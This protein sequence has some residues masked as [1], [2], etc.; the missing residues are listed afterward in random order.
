MFWTRTLLTSLR[1][2]ASWQPSHPGPDNLAAL[3]DTSLRVRN[4]GSTRRS[5]KRRRERLRPRSL[6]CSSKTTNTT[7]IIY[8]L[9]RI[10]LNDL[11]KLYFEIIVDERAEA[12]TVANEA[13]EVVYS[14]SSG[15]LYSDKNSLSGLSSCHRCISLSFSKLLAGDD[16]LSYN[17]TT[18]IL[19]FK[20]NF[21]LRTCLTYEFLFYV[22]RILT[23]SAA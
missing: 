4:L 14:S 17:H 12:L 8:L 20:G 21:S 9:K 11:G 15:I 1:P 2:A 3:T 13:L 19:S 22:T 5:C 7:S 18:V 23:I 16:G 10:F 6:E